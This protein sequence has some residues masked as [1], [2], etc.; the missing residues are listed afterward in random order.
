MNLLPVPRWLLDGAFFPL[1]EVPQWLGELAWAGPVTRA[2]GSLRRLLQ[3]EAV[4]IAYPFAP[5]ALPRAGAVPS[6]VTGLG[7]ALASAARSPS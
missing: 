1:R 3:P 4:G 2:S 5:Q 6:A 7:A